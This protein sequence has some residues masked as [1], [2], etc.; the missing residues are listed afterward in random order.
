METLIRQSFG[1]WQT[2]ATPAA[3][4]RRYIGHETVTVA[5]LSAAAYAAAMAREI[6]TAHQFGASRDLDTFIVAFTFPMLLVNL[7]GGAAES[8]LI[9]DYISRLQT[10]RRR[11]D[12]AALSFSL[13][14]LIGT[15]ALTALLLLGG[16]SLISLL[17]PGF[18][19]SSIDRSTRMFAWLMPFV[20][21]SGAASICRSLLN[22]RRRYA[23]AAAAPALQPAVVA[24]TIVGL[25]ARIGV[26]SLV[27]G[28]LLGSVV[29]VAI[30][31]AKLRAEGF[32]FSWQGISLR[33]TEHSR[34]VRQAALLVAGGLVYHANTV[35]VRIFASGLAEGTV[36]AM[37][38]ALYTCWTVVSIISFAVAT[39]EFPRLSRLAAAEDYRAFG[40]A[41]REGLGK[42]ILFVVPFSIAL[43]VF[44]GP[45]VGL[46]F[47]RGSFTPQAR[48]VTAESLAAFAVGLVP[49]SITWYAP[50]ALFAL[51]MVKAATVLTP[52]GLFINA[53]LGYLLVGRLQHTGVALAYSAS[54]LYIA[55][56]QVYLIR[57]RVRYE[58]SAGA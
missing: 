34:A 9:P 4:V 7:V 45:I 41:F 23:V 33:M 14:I 36:A 15:L 17:A 27:V 46:L 48:E 18:A 8:V 50:R 24:L 2:V 13:V 28:T 54:V 6:V 38:Y 44:S 43:Y 1:W 42:A 20:L 56:L 12:D 37:N 40:Q 31:L 26:E 55:G 3:K 32:R 52:V 35:V 49:L 39:V 5:V 53:L 30:L 21:L 29:V 11:A 10:D 16:R 19:E 57:R 58:L 47:E 22:A 25:A 51:R